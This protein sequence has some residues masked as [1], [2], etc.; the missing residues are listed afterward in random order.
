MHI[1]VQAPIRTATV[2]PAR[3]LRPPA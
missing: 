2:D 1:R 3:K